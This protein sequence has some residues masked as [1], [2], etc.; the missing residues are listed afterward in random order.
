[1]NNKKPNFFRGNRQK[2]GLLGGSFNP[3]HEGHFYISIEALKRL[4]LDAVWWL[5][6]PQNPLKSKSETFPIHQ[7]VSSANKVACHPRIHVT[8]LESRLGTNY[9]VD[10]LSRLKQ[11]L[12]MTRFVWLMGSDNLMQ[13]HYWKRWNKIFNIIPIAVFARET[14]D[15][16][17]LAG[18]AA[19]RYSM[20][21]VPADRVANLVNREPPAWTFLPLRWHPAASR[22]IR[23]SGEW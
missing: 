3:A 11:Q 22:D 15:F 10:T 18:I 14:Y 1:M 17:A 12:P 20:N 4:Q 16:G 19:N 2:I 7:R 9:T 21:R 8:T 13:M 5:V 23:Q 6:T